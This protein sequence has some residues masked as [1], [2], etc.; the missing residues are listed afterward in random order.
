MKVNDKFCL[1]WSLSY[2]SKEISE[3]LKSKKFKPINLDDVYDYQVY[4]SVKY[5]VVDYA[6]NADNPI[7]KVVIYSNNIG[8]AIDEY[9]VFITISVQKQVYINWI[10]KLYK[11]LTK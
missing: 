4:K 11:E 5:L 2:N 8:T 1:L 6:M 7:Q 10:E 9:D 3:I